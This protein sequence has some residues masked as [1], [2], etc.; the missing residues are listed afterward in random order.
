MGASQGFSLPISPLPLPPS[1]PLSSQCPP[2][3]P[4]SPRPGQEIPG[5][6]QLVKSWFPVFPSQAVAQPAQGPSLW[7]PPPSTSQSLREGPRACV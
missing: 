3:A 1:A 2:P 5:R 7:K 4:P 6:S